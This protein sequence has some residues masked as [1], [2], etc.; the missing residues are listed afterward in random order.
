V[1]RIDEAEGYSNKDKGQRMLTV[2][3][4]I[5]MRPIARRSQRWERDGG[6]Q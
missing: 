5:G 6:G 1:T 4:K 3:A 2:L